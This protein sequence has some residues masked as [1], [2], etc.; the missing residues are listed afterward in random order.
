MIVVLSS[1]LRLARWWMMGGCALVLVVA[2]FCLAPADDNPTI[3]N[4][5]KIQHMLAFL[6]LALWFGGI[7][8]RRYLAAM[9]TLLVAY[10]A[11]IELGQGSM[12]LG[13]TA[14]WR[15]LL[16]DAAGVVAGLLLALTPLGRWA[17][18]LESLQ[19]RFA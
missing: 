5:D 6:A 14:D 2:Y 15:D 13:R 16:A 1:G 10:G 7:I 11:L 4:F 12:G 19:R 18:W 9:G 3:N 8:A 17:L